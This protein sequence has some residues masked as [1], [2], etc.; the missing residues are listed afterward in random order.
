MRRQTSHRHEA[1]VVLQ[2]GPCVCGSRA[3]PPAVVEMNGE[4]PVGDGVQ[5]GVEEAKDEKHVS[6]RMRD[7]LLHFVR[8]QPVPQSE[9][10][11]RSPADDE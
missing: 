2:I 9:Q 1:G 5:A 6:E 10:V 8:E 11:V 4:Q 3:P 7:R